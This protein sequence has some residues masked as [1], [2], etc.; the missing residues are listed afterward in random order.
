MPYISTNGNGYTDYICLTNRIHIQ[1][2]SEILVNKGRLIIGY[3]LHKTPLLCCNFSVFLISSEMDAMEKYG[4]HCCLILVQCV[5]QNFESIKKNNKSLKMCSRLSD[6]FQVEV[7]PSG[8]QQC[9]CK[10]LM[11]CKKRKLVA[12][13]CNGVL[14]EL[15]FISVSRTGGTQNCDNIHPPS[16]T[17]NQQGRI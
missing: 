7:G 17:N 11:S 6:T 14:L 16:T 10:R 12:F 8:P 3:H 9:P 1:H 2:S 4:G 15:L 13:C 5:C